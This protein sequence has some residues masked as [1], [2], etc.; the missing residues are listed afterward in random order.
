MNRYKSFSAIFLDRDGVIVENRP[1]YIKTWDEVDFLPN[2]L[3][4][5]RLLAET[6]YRIVIVTNQS[7]VGRG[8]LSFEQAQEINQGVI[9]AVE[10]TGGRVDAS[11]I[12]PHQPAENC[13]C[14]K[15]APGMLNRA[16]K[17]LDINFSKSF[18]IGDAATD[19]QAAQSVGIQGILVKTGR[20]A[21]QLP[22]M[23]SEGM[24][25]FLIAADLTAAVDMILNLEST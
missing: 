23:E 11:Y 16:Q 5:L 12:C 24:R 8:I 2:S 21:E 17:D 7:A 6:Q 3:E 18:M 10:A 22:E 9:D 1:D 14:R 20:G 4:S 25:D 15:P 19:I 13:P